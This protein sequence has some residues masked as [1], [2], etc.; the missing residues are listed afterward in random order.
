[1]RAAKTIDSYEWHRKALVYHKGPYDPAGCEVRRC[2]LNVSPADDATFRLLE[3]RWQRIVTGTLSH[4]F[5]RRCR[6]KALVHS[7]ALLCFMALST[8]KVA[9]DDHHGSAS[10]LKPDAV[11]SSQARDASYTAH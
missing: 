4:G 1:M 6:S 9:C 7:A 5:D 8:V 11:F 2:L 10:T 3:M